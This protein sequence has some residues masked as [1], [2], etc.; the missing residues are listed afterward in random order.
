MP[1]WTDVQHV[2]R[3]EQILQKGKLVAAEPMLS[4]LLS[5]VEKKRMIRKHARRNH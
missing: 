5:I 2:D 4:F 1:P 3:N